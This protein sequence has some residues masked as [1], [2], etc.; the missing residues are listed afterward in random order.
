MTY[1]TPRAPLDAQAQQE[2]EYII[3]ESQLREHA[4]SARDCGKEDMTDFP[5]RERTKANEDELEGIENEIRSRP[6]NPAP[7]SCEIEGDPC[8]CMGSPC[9]RMKDHDEQVKKQERER[10]LKE[11]WNGID[12]TMDF[13]D[14]NSVECDGCILAIT[15][16]GCPPDNPLDTHEIFDGCLI[17]S[18]RGQNES[19]GEPE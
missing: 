13:A 4:R 15:H 17:E 12:C 11:L 2:S 19:K 16:V 10:V 14:A 8:L 5:S 6:H 7:E 1:H 9:S 18:L 3:T